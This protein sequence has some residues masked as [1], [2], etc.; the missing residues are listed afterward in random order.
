VCVYVHVD[1]CTV[2]LFQIA[3]DNTRVFLYSGVSEVAIT[4]KVDDFSIELF[5]NV[6]DN[7]SLQ[8]PS[9]TKGKKVNIDPAQ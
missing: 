7:Y 6:P 3:V 1:S 5:G 9:I 4:Y 8:P 2:S